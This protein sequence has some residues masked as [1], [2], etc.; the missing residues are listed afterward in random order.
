[1]SRCQPK[2]CAFLNGNASSE[3]IGCVEVRSEDEH[4]LVKPAMQESFAR[5]L[6]AALACS[7]DDGKPVH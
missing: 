7:R 5:T 4:L 3:I 2:N 1:M 6:D